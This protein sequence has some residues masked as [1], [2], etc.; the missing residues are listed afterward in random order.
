MPQTRQQKIPDRKIKIVIP[1][2]NQKTLRRST[3]RLKRQLQIPYGAQPFLRSID[4]VMDNADRLLIDSFFLPSLEI[5]VKAF[6]ANDDDLV[7]DRKTIKLSDQ[8]I[9]QSFIPELYKR[10]GDIPRKWI[11]S[12]SKTS[13]ENDGFHSVIDSSWGS[14][15][16]GRH[17]HMLS[18]TEF[19]DTLKSCIRRPSLTL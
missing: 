14:N 7:N 9:K 16:I 11:E 8:V 3:G 1:A 6:T 19:K 5:L 12:C 13:G 18:L 10:F 4:P 17:Q 15:W 2:E